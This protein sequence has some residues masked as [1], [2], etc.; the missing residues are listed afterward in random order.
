M[1]VIL[2]LS[3]LRK[4]FVVRQ[5][6]QGKALARGHLRVLEIDGQRQALCAG[7]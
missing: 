3:I 1:R 5:P 6:R 2:P 4:E 7:I